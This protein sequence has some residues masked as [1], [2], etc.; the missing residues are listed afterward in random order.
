MLPNTV[1]GFSEGQSDG[2]DLIY[3]HD[4]DGTVVT[5]EQTHDGTWSVRA[6]VGDNQPATVADDLARRDDAAEELVE[7]LQSYLPMVEG[8]GQ[9]GGR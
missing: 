2:R 4:D 1:N 5:A 3:T 9:G 6:F 7:Y 8:A